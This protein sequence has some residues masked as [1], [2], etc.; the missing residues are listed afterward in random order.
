MDESGSG[1]VAH[2]SPDQDDA[3]EAAYRDGYDR[4]IRE[5]RWVRSR[6][7]TPTERQITVALMQAARVYAAARGGR[8][9]A[10]Q[11]PEW[12]RGRVDALRMLVRRGEEML[13]SDS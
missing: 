8:S 11:R 12:L 9:V 4:V 1:G 7:W 2:V 10:G 5:L 3:D 13:P 6:G